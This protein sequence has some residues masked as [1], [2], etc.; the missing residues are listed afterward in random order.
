MDSQLVPAQLLPE[1]FLGRSHVTAFFPHFRFSKW[2]DVR[3]AEGLGALKFFFGDRLT[4]DDACPGPR[5]RVLDWHGGIV[6]Q[7][8]KTPLPSP[9]R[10]RS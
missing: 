1:D 10:G 8:R 5:R 9:P 4:W 7:N 2:G 3:R 6:M